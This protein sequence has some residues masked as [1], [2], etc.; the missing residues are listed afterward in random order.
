MAQAAA[1]T[2]E[3]TRV[4][5]AVV[6]ASASCAFKTRGSL[7]CPL[8]RNPKMDTPKTFSPTP[9]VWPSALNNC[10]DPDGS[11]QKAFCALLARF[12]WL[13]KSKTG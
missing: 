10:F 5:R 12:S 7:S 1:H 13:R 2:G 3:V 4:L 11:A 6:A 8:V 9:A